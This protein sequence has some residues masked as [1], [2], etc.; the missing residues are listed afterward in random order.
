[1]K[2]QNLGNP[3]KYSGEWLKNPFTLEQNITKNDK[4][5]RIK[6]SLPKKFFAE[7]ELTVWVVGVRMKC[8][9]ISDTEIEIISYDNVFNV[10][11]Q[12][13][14]LY[15]LDNFSAVYS[16]ELVPKSELSSL[17]RKFERVIE[18]LSFNH[19]QR[20]LTFIGN[21]NQLS[22]VDNPK[23]GDIAKSEDKFW[24]FS[25]IML[26]CVIEKVTK[27]EL[28]ITFLG[29]AKSHLKDTCI[30]ND[31]TYTLSFKK[32]ESERMITFIYESAGVIPSVSDPIYV[33]EWTECCIP[34]FFMKQLTSV[35]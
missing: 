15:V 9:Y 13:A 30:I 16:E 27:N 4:I 20:G 28:T 12:S 3:L 8:R 33:S 34:A 32:K 10:I 31:V 35:M 29:D 1:M 24:I 25:K 11:Q 6:T 5:V 14:T 17:E 18:S 19:I 21:F 23:H 2:S 22:D 7:Q 26:S